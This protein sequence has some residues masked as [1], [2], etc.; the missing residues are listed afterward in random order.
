MKSDSVHKPATSA[1]DGAERAIDDENGDS[2]PQT[3]SSVLRSD[4]VIRINRSGDRIVRERTTRFRAAL[5]A[6]TLVLSLWSAPA[7]NAYTERGAIKTEYD[8]LGGARVLGQPLFDERAALDGGRFQEFSGGSSIYWHPTRTKGAARQVGGAIRS[9]WSQ[10]GYERGWLGY[11]ITSETSTRKPGR[12]NHFENGSIYWSSATGAHAVKGQIYETWAGHDWEHGPYGFPVGDETD[13]RSL[14]TI[15]LQRLSWPPKISEQSSPNPSARTVDDQVCDQ[16]RMNRR[17]AP[18][19]AGPRSMTPSRQKGRQVACP[20]PADAVPPRIT[21]Q[22][23]AL[24]GM[25]SGVWQASINNVCYRDSKRT[26]NIFDKETLAKTGSITGIESVGI[27]TRWNDLKFDVEYSFMPT[28]ITGTAVGATLK[29][30]HGCRSGCA[31]GGNRSSGLAVD[32]NFSYL[33][34]HVTTPTAG[35]PVDAIP[36]VSITLTG[37]DIDV[38]GYH[39]FVFPAARCDSEPKMKNNGGCRIK[40]VRPVWDIRSRGDLDEYRRHVRLAQDSGLPGRRIT[41]AMANR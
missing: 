34:H 20:A 27:D 17:P 2:G 11:P 22:D 28:T 3:G 30:D 10:L 41:R 26:W 40:D 5:V 1:A 24:C 18:S 14:G 21:P 37:D 32:S 29:I 31:T 4:H 12:F 13:A 16:A 36:R 15:G 39:E 9:K 23:I 7:A 35:S 6:A 19:S 33:I 25:D 38:P 8:R